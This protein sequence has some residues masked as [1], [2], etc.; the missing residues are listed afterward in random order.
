M[1]SR[2]NSGF[3]LFLQIFQ[4]GIAVW[5]LWPLF[6][7]QADRMPLWR[8]M[9]GILLV[10]IGVGRLFYDSIFDFYK[11]RKEQQPLVALLSLIVTITLIAAL[12]GGLLL[13]FV[14][15]AV[16]R[17]NQSGGDNN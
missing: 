11:K 14:V 2:P 13:L 16:S 7:L 8:M 5:L 3:S 10:V 12:V 4:W 17:L 6:V 9:T 1:K 15:Y